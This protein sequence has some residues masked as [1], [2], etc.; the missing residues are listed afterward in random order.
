MSQYEI[1]NPPDWK[2][3]PSNWIGWRSIAYQA[4][5]NESFSVVILVSSCSVG[6]T[7]IKR[8]PFGIKK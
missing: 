6:I 4:S 5:S 7:W 8:F 2:T 1:N 3:G